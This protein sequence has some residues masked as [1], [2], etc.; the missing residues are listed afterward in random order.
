MKTEVQSRTINGCV[1]TTNDI[2]A[3][4]HFQGFCKKLGLKPGFR[5]AE[6]CLYQ[7]G[8][9]GSGE[10]LYAVIGP[11]LALNYFPAVIDGVEVR[12]GDVL[13]CEPFQARCRALGIDPT[14][15]SLEQ[16][17][18]ARRCACDEHPYTGLIL[19]IVKSLRKKKTA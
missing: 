12:A 16:L 14:R 15:Y 6:D 19:V 4:S 2:L 9:Y 7:R 3:S 8:R 13:A 18:E 10:I 1:V 17:N 11:R 5:Q